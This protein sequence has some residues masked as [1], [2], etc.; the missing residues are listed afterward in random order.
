MPSDQDVRVS[1][2]I[3]AFNE[4]AELLQTVLSVAE[5]MC[6]KAF[7]II[8]VDDGSTDDC[9]QHARIDEHVKIAHDKRNGVAC[10]RDEAVHVATG[11]CFAFLD[12]HQR[13][14]HGCLSECSRVAMRE[15]AIVCPDTMGF[16]QDDRTAHGANFYFARARPPFGAKWR[17]LKPEKQI[18]RV[19]SLK[20]PAYVIPAEIYP[21][22][23]WSRLLRGW[24]GSE[25]SVSLKAFFTDTPI[26][27]LCGPIAYHK[28]K[29]TFHY[30][31][32]WDEIWRNHALIARICF[33][34][35][36]W[37]DY[38]LPEVFAKHLSEK[39]QQEMDS[40][41]VKA[42]HLEFQQIKIRPDHEFWTRLAF[43]K[44]PAAVKR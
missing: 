1:V 21:K 44:V 4:G 24:G 39:T 19:R 20:A 30:E 31:V 34:E 25:G 13:L 40:D 22:V 23:R 38:W 18:T 8:V 32:T 9:V 14:T 10:S 2:V 35:S 27:H 11:E 43:Q 6:S 37:Y 42:E 16:E 36:T 7:E 29:K 26:L 33:S 15:N 17:L 5:C 28:F 41:A 12:G 3:T